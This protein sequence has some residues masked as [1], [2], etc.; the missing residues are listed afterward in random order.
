MLKI[1]K[2]LLLKIIEDIDA[3][4]S[5]LTEAETLDVINALKEYT[6]KDKR[7]RKYS[8][9]EYLHISRATFDNYVKEGKLPQGEHDLGFKE[10][11]WKLKDLEH[12]KETKYDH[13]EK[14]MYTNF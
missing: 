14:D 7:I 13:R 11:S 2:E 12:F 1:I 10:K 5:T 4:T 3:G 8:A 6:N 9:C